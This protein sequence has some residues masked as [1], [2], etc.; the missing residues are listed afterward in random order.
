M[1]LYF[2]EGF[3]RYGAVADL[4]VR[5][6]RNSGAYATTGGV[7]NGGIWTSSSSTSYIDFT[8][9]AAIAHGAGLVIH[10]AFWLKVNSFPSG[11]NPSD[12][13][14]IGTNQVGTGSTT[15]RLFGLL[16]DG[17]ITAKTHGSSPTQHNSATGVLL[18]G[19]WQHVELAARYADSGGFIKVWVD[20]VLVIDVAGDTQATGT[21][22]TS[23]TGFRTLWTNGTGNASFDDILVWDE[24]NGD[25]AHTQLP[26]EHLIETLSVN[27]DV[28]TQLTRSGGATNAEALDE[29][30]FHDAD[31]S[32]VESTAVGQADLYS[33]ADQAQ[34]P[35]ATLA[36]AVHSRAKKTDAGAVTMRHRLK[37]GGTTVEGADRALTTSYAHY[38]DYWGLN[39]DT[40]A[41]WGTTDVNGVQAGLEHQA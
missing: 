3:D 30:G 23:V 5:Y 28:A 6:T 25:F 34:T 37:H 40:A 11:T 21:A 36:V 15:S 41:A 13:F 22:P 32:Y 10:A 31:T 18:L 7:A 14:A 12:L 35:L 38:S 1:T 26:H 29:T 39:P 9:P 24:A 33:L 27:G 20:R 17:T 4:A 8:F 19:Q 2:S 16:G